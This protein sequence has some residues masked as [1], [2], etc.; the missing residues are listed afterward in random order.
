MY[1]IET[2][3]PL[4]ETRGNPKSYP[5]AKMK[6]GESFF[7]PTGER[8][9]TSLQSSLISAARRHEGKFTTRALEGG[10]R[11]WRVE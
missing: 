5:F 8:T 4:E 7:V 3:I 10:V 2:D 1:E 6:I 9:I 11:V